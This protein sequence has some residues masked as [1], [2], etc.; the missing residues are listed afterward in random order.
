M[1]SFCG[2]C[3]VDRKLLAKGRVSYSG[4]CSHSAVN[5]ICRIKVSP[6]LTL[7]SQIRA[8]EYLMSNLQSE[9]LYVEAHGSPLP[10]A[11]VF[12]SRFK[13]VKTLS[14]KILIS[15]RT[16]GTKICTRLEEHVTKCHLQ[17][18]KASVND[19]K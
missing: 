14:E 16:C 5:I 12:D 18:K 15:G 17:L 13:L 9:L 1:L 8:Y 10:Q 2:S 11:Q 7:F 6:I 19:L 4:T 3:N